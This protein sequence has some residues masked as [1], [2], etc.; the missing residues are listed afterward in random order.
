MPKIQKRGRS[1]SPV[2]KQ[3]KSEPTA[4]VNRVLLSHAGLTNI[5][6]IHRSMQAL[7]THQG[8]RRR[9]QTL[10]SNIFMTRLRSQLRS[11]VLRERQQES[12][13]RNLQEPSLLE[14]GHDRL[15]SSSLCLFLHLLR[16]L[17]LLLLLLLNSILLLDLLLTLGQSASLYRPQ[18][19]YGSQNPSQRSG[20]RSRAMENLTSSRI[21]VPPSSLS[22][23]PE[24]AMTFSTRSTNQEGQR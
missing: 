9:S 11:V 4:E 2:P 12:K 1:Q 16:L 13:R 10:H 14:Q 18:S 5:H 17:L 21:I 24:H 8:I 20:R 7:V 22:S 23:L 15:I 19:R 6:L 3:F